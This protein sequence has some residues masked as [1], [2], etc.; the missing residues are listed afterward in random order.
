MPFQGALRLIDSEAHG[1]ALGWPTRRFQRRT[2]RSGE[3]RQIHLE[4]H[5]SLQREE[6]CELASTGRSS[7]QCPLRALKGCRPPRQ[8][9]TNAAG[10]DNH[11]KPR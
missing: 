10:P 8:A 7:L 4:P 9:D 11:A 6:S 3:P 5:C 2:V 1:I